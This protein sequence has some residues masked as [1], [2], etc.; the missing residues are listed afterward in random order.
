M[1]AQMTPDILPFAPDLTFKAVRAS[2]A[3][4][5]MPPHIPP[6][7]FAIEIEKTS[8]RWLKCVLVMLSVYVCM[9]MCM[10]I[11]ENTSI[12]LVVG[13]VSWSCCLV[14]IHTYIYI[15]TCMHTHIHTYICTYMNAYIHTYIHY[16]YMHAYIPI[17]THIY[18]HI[19]TIEHDTENSSHH[20]HIHTHI[21]VVHIRAICTEVSVSKMMTKAIE[22]DAENSSCT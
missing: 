21:H 7:I 14:Y 12:A 2:A 11:I 17:Y 19:Y 9:Y 10:Y 20:T 16:T 3:V 22:H 4:P 1:H 6:I 13:I 18:T 8:L 5:G 15:F